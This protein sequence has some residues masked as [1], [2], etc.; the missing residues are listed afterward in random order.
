MLAWLIALL[1]KAGLSETR[2]IAV[3]TVIAQHVLAIVV[4]IGLVV[5]TIWLTHLGGE[6]REASIKA[7]WDEKFK[8]VRALDEE[9]TQRRGK[10]D[11]EIAIAVKAAIDNL[12][13]AEPVPPS[14]PPLS[15]V[16]SVSPAAPSQCP[17]IEYQLPASAAARLNA[18]SKGK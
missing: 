11:S 13:K 1:I 7:Q 2:S 9:L 18:I 4:A 10:L 16:I 12:P 17:P 5:Y 6:W 3:G 8:Q 15:P 14:C